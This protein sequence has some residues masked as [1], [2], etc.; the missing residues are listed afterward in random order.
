MNKYKIGQEVFIKIGGRV[1][2]VFIKEVSYQYEKIVY[3]VSKFGGD[4]FEEHLYTSWW[5]CLLF[6]K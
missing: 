2:K 3:W 4:I 5:K 6:S 1:Y